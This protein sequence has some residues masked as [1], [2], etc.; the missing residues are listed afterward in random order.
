MVCSF[1]LAIGSKW[2]IIGFI[3]GVS[4]E[5]LQVFHQWLSHLFLILSLLHT[6]PFVV[7]GATKRP[8]DDGMSPQGYS[9]LES[10]TIPHFLYYYWTGIAALVPLVWLCWGSLSPLRHRF[11]EL[12]KLLHIVLAIIFCVFFHID[13][14]NLLTSWHYL[15]A[16]ASVHFTSVVMRFGLIP[17]ATAV[18]LPKVGSK[19]SPGTPFASRSAYRKT[20]LT[21]GRRANISLS[22]FSSTASP[23]HLTLVFCVNPSTGLG[24]RLLRLASSA[25]PT[26][27]VLLDGPYGGLINRDLGRHDTIV[28]IAGEAGMSFITAIS[29]ELAGRAMREDPKVKGL[30]R[31]EVH[32]A[33]RN[34]EAKTWFDEQLGGALH[35]LVKRDGF[36][37][38]DLYVT[39]DEVGSAAQTPTPALGFDGKNAVVNAGGL[40]KSA[41]R[42]MYPG[43]FIATVP[44]SPPSKTPSTSSFTSAAPGSTVGIGS[45]G[46][47]SLVSDVRR[48]VDRRQRQIAFGK[49]AD[50]VGE[51]EL[52]A[53][54]FDW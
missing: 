4:H 46:P 18:T 17:S 53:E 24:P 44:T 23:S 32:W 43:P 15:S 27:P 14:D 50:G 41:P 29:Q 12:S 7:Q 19:V 11:Y 2:N 47:P 6:F 25:N 1:I 20:A 36:L 26:T 22:I 16:T 37:K 48:S 34:E 33:V 10:L 39:G 5:K 45:C 49:A 13:C 30:K 28:L 21:A 52:H 42:R 9:Q 54:V 40:E 51:V 38:L 8:N 35:H 3:V 31:I